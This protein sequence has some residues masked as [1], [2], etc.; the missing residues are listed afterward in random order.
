MS[1]RRK[2]SNS[3]ASSK[4]GWPWWRIARRLA[5]AIVVL[6]AL[7]YLLAPLYRFTNPV[8]TLMLWR[9]MTG[10]R[11]EHAW[12]PIEGIAPVL[13]LAVIGA[14]DGTFCHNRGIDL[15]AMREA[16]EQS[17]D[18]LGASRGASTITQ[19]AAKNL[20]LWQGRSFVRKALELPLALWLNIVLP[21]RRVLE[22]YLNIV[23]WGPNGE[24]GA[25]AAS[26]WAFN[27]SARGLNTQEAAELA[28][29]LPNPHLRSARNPTP[30]VRRLAGV[31]VRRSADFANLDACIRAH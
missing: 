25:E 16:V 13:P 7:P 17:D 12:V 30:L 31:Y 21:K 27:R 11:V 2:S 9:W 29:I 15:A 3:N 22:I 10:Q 24:F 1:P 4:T 23:E 5:I 26:H 20:F 18:D 28:S 14:E 8:S 6:L 19:Q